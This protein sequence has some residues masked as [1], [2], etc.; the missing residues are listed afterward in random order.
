VWACCDHREIEDSLERLDKLTQEE[1]QMASAEQLK[2]T[3]SIDG[4]VMGVEDRVR[5]VEGQV[6]GVR[7]DVQ[8]VCVNVQDVHVNVQ[9]VHVDVQDVRVD[10]QGVCVDVQDVLTTRLSPQERGTCLHVAIYA[11]HIPQSDRSV[12][13]LILPLVMCGPGSAQKPGLRPGLRGLRL[14]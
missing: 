12:S 11:S 1:A 6:E 7:G 14:S 5:G 2:M 4:K 8:D 10:I 9:D 3:H 13:F